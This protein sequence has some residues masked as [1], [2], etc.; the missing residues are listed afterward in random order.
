MNTDYE[1]FNFT[2]PIEEAFE[3]VI[4]AV[5]PEGAVQLPRSTTENL[6]VGMSIRFTD[7]AA[8]G[9]T[10]RVE[11]GPEPVTAHSI[12]DLYA[13]G[14]I[15]IDIWRHRYDP[16]TIAAAEPDT[17]ARDLLSHYASRVRY[18]LCRTDAATL[19]AALVSPKLSH[20][21]PLA[22]QR[23][24][25]EEM[26]TDHYV[27]AYEINY[28]IPQSVLPNVLRTESGYYIRTEAGDRITI[29]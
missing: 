15:E 4:E 12:Y 29:E 7:G 23:F 11:I 19:N 17:T 20:I 18:A 6:D 24:T 22:S 16:E 9:H 1:L 21:R 25:D 10:L 8:T 5:I 14:T 13:G 26:V 3:A 27:L 2:D 28:G